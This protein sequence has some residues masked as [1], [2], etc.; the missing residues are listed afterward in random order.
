MLGAAQFAIGI[1]RARAH[2]GRQQAA[3]LGGMQQGDVAAV[4][5]QGLVLGGVGEHQQLHRELGVHHAAGAVLHIEAAFGHGARL[6]YLFPHGPHFFAQGIGLARSAEHAAAH[7]LKARCQRG[8]TG[9]P[10]GAGD[11][12]VFPGPGGVAAP[13]QLV[14]LKGVQR[15]HQQ[16]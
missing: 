12:L 3:G 9:A 2:P 14:A 4:G 13:A 7:P 1:G 15:G 16:A 8:H 10:A 5:L 11:R 6:A